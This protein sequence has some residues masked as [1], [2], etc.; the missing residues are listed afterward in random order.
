M[1]V[2]GAR[3]EGGWIGATV[4][5]AGIV[6]VGALVVLTFAGRSLSA[7]PAFVS[8]GVVLLPYLYAAVAAT[9]FL[10]WAM[11]PDRRA[12]P[13]TL[14]L[15]LAIAA[16]I[17]GPRW[18]VDGQPVEGAAVRVMSWNLRRLWGGPDDGGD[19][20]SCVVSAIEATAPDVLT[21]LEVSANDVALLS[22]RLDLVCVQH[23]YL[24]GGAPK[25][26]GLA[27]CTR[28]A[29]W[30]FRS[31]AGRRYVDHEDWYYVAGEVESAHR[32]F[33]V[34]AV[35]LSPYEYVAK[36]LK[37]S[38]SE[39]TRGEPDPIVDLSR[40]SETIVRGQSDQSAA[41]L[42]RVDKFR[43]PSV[44]GGDFNSTRDSALHAALREVL[45]DTWE[46][47]GE[48]FGGTVHLF[49]WLP[50][51]IDYIYASHEFRV[52]KTSV[53]DVGCSDHQAVVTDLVLRAP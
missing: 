27:L 19:A 20:T 25:T 5:A 16:G 36:K 33:N 24:E 23:P 2:R 12:L 15:L 8:A 42:E 29:R 7:P 53:L 6:A 26:G 4:A 46:I 37:A 30:R 41:L 49:D 51:R 34:L 22:E 11:F 1:A 3:R 13:A 17:W 21:L 32:V 48:G 31:G 43:D 39:L 47:G 14:F 45:K 35:H 44:V 40:R 9:L 50:L 52:E 28:G 10:A 38:V 18:G